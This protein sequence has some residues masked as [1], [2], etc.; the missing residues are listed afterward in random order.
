MKHTIPWT[1]VHTEYKRENE[2][3][4]SFRVSLTPDWTACD[5]LRHGLATVVPLAWQIDYTLKLWAKTTHFASNA[6]VNILAH[7]HIHTLTHKCYQEWGCWCDQTNHVVHR[8][9]GFICGKNALEFETEA[10]RRSPKMLYVALK[11]LVSWEFGRQECQHAGKQWWCRSKGF[12][13]WAKILLE[14]GLE[15]IHA[16]VL[17]RVWLHSAYTRATS[18]KQ[19]SKIVISW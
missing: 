5:Q 11:R 1:V 9:L 6:S 17:Q 8:L 19:R 7:T 4:T 3:T 12:R 15:F 2:W 13:S 10:W 14:T 18:V 16:K